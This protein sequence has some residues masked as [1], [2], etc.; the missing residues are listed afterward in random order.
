MT[1]GFDPRR[2]SGDRKPNQGAKALVISPIS[3]NMFGADNWSNLIGCNFLAASN[4][5]KD[6]SLNFLFFALCAVVSSLQSFNSRMF[7]LINWVSLL[8]RW[9]EM[10]WMV[11]VNCSQHSTVVSS[12]CFS[13]C[14]VR[15]VVIS[16]LKLTCIMSFCLV[17]SPVFISRV[18]VGMFNAFSASAQPDRL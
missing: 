15:P 13:E 4:F 8:T 2:E 7:S 5:Q 16:T 10:G 9:L 6:R 18:Q 1:C 14:L 12:L 11:Y 17:K 3:N